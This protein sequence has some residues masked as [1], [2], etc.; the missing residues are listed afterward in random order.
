MACWLEGNRAKGDLTCIIRSISSPRGSMQLWNNQTRW[1]MAKIIVTTT[2]GITL[3]GWL[4]HAHIA[5]QQAIPCISDSQQHWFRHLWGDH[6]RALGSCAKP[7]SEVALPTI[8]HTLPSVQSLHSKIVKVTNT[9]Y[10]W[11]KLRL[12]CLYSE[13][14]TVLFKGTCWHV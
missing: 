3:A 8:S 12:D 5:R 4:Y 13:L 10:S 6:M 7:H 9:L 14:C 1:T 2:S 11:S